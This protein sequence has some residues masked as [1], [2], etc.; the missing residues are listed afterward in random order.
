LPWDVGNMTTQQFNFAIYSYLL[1]EGKNINLL[2]D[3]AKDL[4]KEWDEKLAKARKKTKSEIIK[5]TTEKI[6]KDI[7]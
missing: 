1:D 7:K 4:D 6:M 2:Q 3:P 5:E